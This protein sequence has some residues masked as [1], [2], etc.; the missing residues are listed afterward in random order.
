M[1]DESD[2]K[3]TAEAL[4]VKEHQSPALNT[5]DHEHNFATAAHSGK[6]TSS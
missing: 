6:E 2:G 4:A 5:L 1:I 3:R